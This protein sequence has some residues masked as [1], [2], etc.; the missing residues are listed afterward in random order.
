M[1]QSISLT[2]PNDQWLKAQVDS[3]EFTS[4][5]EV[6]NDLIRQARR[7]QQEAEWIRAQL[8]E[9]ERSGFIEVNENTR[10]EMLAKFKAQAQ[11]DGK[12]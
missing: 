6:V 12:L 10:R 5:S 8:I 2:E 4:K 3:Q 9:G 7:K 1:R 11:R